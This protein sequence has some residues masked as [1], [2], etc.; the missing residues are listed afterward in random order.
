[1]MLYPQKIRCII[2]GAAGCNFAPIAFRA[3]AH[4]RR[5]SHTNK[6]TPHTCQT[7]SHP[8]KNSPR[9]PLDANSSLHSKGLSFVPSGLKFNE[10]PPVLRKLVLRS[11]KAW[12]QV[13][14][15]ALAG[16]DQALFYE[17]PH[18]ERNADI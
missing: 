5:H 16:A 17:L 15:W 4:P 9:Y 8:A 1:M 14:D 7:P 2:P 10:I 3:R 18:G 13:P 6:K 11:T 12:I